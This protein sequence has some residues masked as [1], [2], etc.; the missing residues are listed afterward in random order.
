MTAKVSE[1]L[2]IVEETT[3]GKPS[4]QRF[5]LLVIMLIGITVLYLDRVNISII[6]ADEKFLTQMGILGDPVKIGLLMTTFLG[7]YAIA[8]VVLAPLGDYLGPRKSMVMAYILICISLFLGGISGS[9]AML[10]AA[11]IILGI[12]E[13]FYYPMQNTFVRNWFPPKE[14]GRA[15]S[16][17][18]V[19]QS[20]S[21]AVAIPIFTF[22]VVTFSWQSTFFFA[23]IVSLIP[24]SLIWFYTADTPRKHKKVNELELK[25][26][27]EEIAKVEQDQNVNTSVKE[28][29]WERVKPFI[30]NYQFWLLVFTFGTI[31]IIGWGLATWLPSYLKQARG[32]SWAEMGWLAALPFLF[33]ILFSASSGFLSDKIG[34]SAPVILLAELLCCVGVYFGTIVENNYLAAVLIAFGQGVVTMAVP[35]IFTLLQSMVPSK[36]ISTAAGTLNGIAVGF[37]ALSPVLFGFF[38]SLTGNYSSALYFL[39]GAGLLGAILAGVL[40]M[41]KL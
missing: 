26:I 31:S 11:R 18:V 36:A 22:L 40:A 30:L 32:F 3:T 35:A 28:S 16:T 20:L 7:A 15:N 33:G 1:E 24:L 38:I 25:Y 5:H 19:G 39:V 4:R 37:G 9:F 29:F 8:N 17:W 14:R 21:Q 6:V 12:G 23:L 34:R 10:I 13:G 41:K 2:K 27:E